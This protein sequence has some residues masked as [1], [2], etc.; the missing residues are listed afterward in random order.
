M[1]IGWRPRGSS[2]STVSRGPRSGSAPA[3]A[4]SAW[5]SCAARAGSRR[6]APLRSSAARWLTPKRCCSSTTTTAEPIELRPPSSISA[7]VPTISDSS[8]L[9]SLPSRSA[10]RPRRRRAGQQPGSDRL[11]AEQLLDRR[12][13]LLGERLGRRH[14][15]GLVAVL[16]RAQHRV[17]RDD[18][19]AGADLAHQQPLHRARRARDPR[20]SPRSP[21]LVAG[22][23]ERE[24]VFQPAR[25]ELGAPVQ[26][27]RDGARLSAAPALLQGQLGQQQL[28]EG[29]PPPSLLL[30]VWHRSESA[31]PGALPG[32]SGSRSR[33]RTRRGSGSITSSKFAACC[34]HQREDLGRG[35]PVGGRVVRDAGSAS[36]PPAIGRLA[37]SA[38]GPAR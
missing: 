34:V 27:R 18:G 2:R 23:R 14:Q 29:E 38:H 37:R 33:S 31:R 28:V 11:G 26:H 8:P 7:W 3:S 1:A 10:R 20:R 30:V 5:R 17:E 4:G 19:L 32:R 13:V 36:A 15:R 25:R 9:A 12:E 22:Q 16:D 6:R 21:P 35:E 24:P